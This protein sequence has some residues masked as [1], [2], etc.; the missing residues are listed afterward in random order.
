MNNAI[1]WDVRL[2]GSCKN[3]C[4]RGTY[5]L[6]L[7]SALRL[8]VTDNVVPSSAILLIL[9]MEAIRPSEMSVLRRDTRRNIQGEDFLQPLLNPYCV[10]I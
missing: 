9:K 2:C 10:T 6:N 7:R 3:R 8:L 5:V 4:F 1:F